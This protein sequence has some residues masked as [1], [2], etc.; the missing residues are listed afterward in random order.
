VRFY[1]DNV[2]TLNASGLINNNNLGIDHVS[3]GGGITADRPVSWYCAGAVASTEYVGPQQQE[4]TN[5]LSA[6]PL[7]IGQPCFGGCATNAL[8]A[9]FITFSKIVS[10]L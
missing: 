5:S 6:T 1:L 10:Y 4:I 9:L 7:T 2:E 3:V 8:A